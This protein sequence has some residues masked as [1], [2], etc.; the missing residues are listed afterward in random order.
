MREANTR[1]ERELTQLVN[2]V[3]RLRGSAYAFY[4]S[5]TS[6]QR[7]SFPALTAALTKRITPVHLKSVQSSKFHERKQQKTE[8]VDAYAQEL[9]LLYRAYPLGE[10]GSPEAET[11]GR[12]VLSCQ[13]IAGLFSTIK[14]KVAGVEGDFEQLVVK[15]RFEEAKLCDLGQQVTYN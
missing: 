13:F 5:S 10:Q 8:T 6:Q 15:A 2:L 3:T 11:M 12:T 1:L 14:A 7:A 9:K 4:R